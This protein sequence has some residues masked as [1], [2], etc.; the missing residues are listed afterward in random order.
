MV[1]SP[2]A[3]S[4][5]QH[6]LPVVGDE[7]VFDGELAVW[8][9]HLKAENKAAR[10][11]GRYADDVRQLDRF[12]RAQGMPTQIE[13][14]TRE[15]LESWIVWLLE[16]WSPVTAESRYKGIQQFFRWAHEE[17]LIDANPMGRMKPPKAEVRERRVLSLDEI[18]ALI[19]SAAGRSFEDRRD[20]AML[21]VFFD[22]GAR[23]GEVAGLHLT[24][25]DGT[26]DI[27]LANGTLLLHGK[28]DRWRAVSLGK[29]TLRSLDRY[30]RLRRDHAR[31]DRAELWLGLKGPMTTSG[32]RQMFKRRGQQAGLGEHIH[33]HLARHAFA[34]HWLHAGGAEQDLMALAGWRSRAMLG[35]YGASA[36]AERA[37]D[38]HRR[39]FGLIDRL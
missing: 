7:E 4:I 11:L 23:L 18:R 5:E 39:G 36:A 22:T 33:P 10:T 8:L 9:R 30:L 16:R 38:A 6:T 34:S 28:G 29:D 27:D 12:V 19:K 21:S 25:P 13:H 31:A 14:M 20:A 17:G 15:H 37:R 1:A 35:R 24:R 32:I 2:S 26:S 3:P